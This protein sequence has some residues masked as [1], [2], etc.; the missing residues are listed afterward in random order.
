MK[1]ILKTILILLFASA[2]FLSA[3]EPKP[4]LSDNDLSALISSLGDEKFETREASQS[5]LIELG[6]KQ[7]DLIIRKCLDAFSESKDPEI[8]ARLKNILRTLVLER[9]FQRKGFIGISMSNSGEQIEIDGVKNE[10]YFPVNVVNVVPDF[11]ADKNGF[12]VGDQ[13]LKIDDKVC[14]PEFQCTNIVDYISAKKPGTK[15][16][17]LVLS[18]KKAVVREFE[19]TERPEMPG[20]PKVEEQQD[21][22]FNKWFKQNQKPPAPKQQEKL[23]K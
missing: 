10:K 8:R 20:E 6:K 17:F 14:S 5:K 3:E 7:Y 12:K 18:E 16:R 11:P 15:M 4:A 2:I 21:D 13:L 9:N 19:I 1:I 23:L 22:F